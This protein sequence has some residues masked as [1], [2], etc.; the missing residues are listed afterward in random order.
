MRWNEFLSA[1]ARVDRHHQ[2]E[3]D[4]A[5]DVLDRLGA[6]RGIERDAGFLAERLDELHR[7]VHVRPGFGM[8]RNDVGAGGGERRDERVHR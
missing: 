7:A 2:D 1:E 4:I 5:E 6:G 3:V 8:N